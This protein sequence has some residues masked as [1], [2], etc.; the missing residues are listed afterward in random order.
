MVTRKEL[1]TK[2]DLQYKDL[3]AEFFET[4]NVGTP[5]QER[6]RKPDKLAADVN[7]RFAEITQNYEAELA[8]NGFEQLSPPEKPPRDLEAEIDDLKAQ[9]RRQR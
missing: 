8:A 9:L 4:I 6:R 5:M 1:A 2:Y 3:D 7:A